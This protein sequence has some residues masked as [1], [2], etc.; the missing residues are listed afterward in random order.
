LNTI[1]P[2]SHDANLTL[3]EL[4][5]IAEEIRLIITKNLS[6]TLDQY[7]KRA[8]KISPTELGYRKIKAICNEPKLEIY[9]PDEV[10][11]ILKNRFSVKKL[12]YA[13]DDDKE[14]ISANRARGYEWLSKRMYTSPDALG[15]LVARQGIKIIG[16][17]YEYTKDHDEF[18]RKYAHNGIKWLSQKLL[19]SKDAI[20][21]KAKRM[22][23]QLANVSKIKK[24]SNEDNQFIRENIDKGLTYLASQL[25]V[26]C[27]AMESKIKRM[28]LKL[29]CKN[30]QFMIENS[31]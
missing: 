14:F 26:S 4:G 18:I 16:Q 21:N 23:V 10:F 6:L 29:S 27:K 5:L 30:E 11:E 19:V 25:G 13:N 8:E 12:I 17:H 20:R 7:K 15:K 3:E 24:Y 28:G 1:E 22:G 9:F 2:I 31:A